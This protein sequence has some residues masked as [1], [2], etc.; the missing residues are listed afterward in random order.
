[1]YSYFSLVTSHS[2]HFALPTLVLPALIS[3]IFPS[4]V[5]FSNTAHKF[6][7]PHFNIDMIVQ[8]A[9][10][11]HKGLPGLHSSNSQTNNDASHRYIKE[12]HTSVHVFAVYYSAVRY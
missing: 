3:P 11:Y 8:I 12:R 2:L 5:E 1:M 10:P 9:T 7:L 4:Q 6:R